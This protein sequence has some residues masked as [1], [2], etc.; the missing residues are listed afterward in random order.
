[1]ALTRAITFDVQQWQSFQVQEMVECISE[2]LSSP[3]SETQVAQLALMDMLDMCG[4]LA[5]LPD[6]Q[7]EYLGC[8]VGTLIAREHLNGV[9]LCIALRHIS[10]AFGIGTSGE[11]S[12][13]SVPCTA[14]M[15]NETAA[16][17]TGSGEYLFG[18]R[19]VEQCKRALRDY[20]D[21]A[22]RIAAAPAMQQANAALADELRQMAAHGGS[23][24]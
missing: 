24:A 13:L 1:M 4:N 16:P 17:S 11:S 10:E 22:G 15:R 21:I 6:G 7:K 23:T 2:L 18:L 20:P 8:L 9:M 12:A 3:E 19:A 5:G 14:D